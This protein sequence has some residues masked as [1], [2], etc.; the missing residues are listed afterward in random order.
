MG[1]YNK[2]AVCF[3][4]D[5]A[6]VRNVLVTMAHNYV[7]GADGLED[8]GR[9]VPDEGSFEG[10]NDEG[11]RIET[12]INAFNKLLPDPFYAF[13]PTPQGS[14]GGDELPERL[15]EHESMKANDGTALCRLFLEFYSYDELVGWD[16][17]EFTRSLPE[18]RY[19]IA[20]AYMME[21]YPDEVYLNL[22]NFKDGGEFTCGPN[23]KPPYRF[24][25]N[26]DL[27]DRDH[28]KRIAREFEA[29]RKNPTT[30]TFAKEPVIK[31]MRRWLR[32]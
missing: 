10:F 7:E 31:A 29:E 32:I 30:E 24:C 19:A 28:A 9:I 12:I 14:L 8:L 17:E 26:T 21:D 20:A 3:C 6:H 25:F 15:I 18:G 11:T 13:N 1:R 5:E 23:A 16:L 22:G 4:G 27:Y 2:N